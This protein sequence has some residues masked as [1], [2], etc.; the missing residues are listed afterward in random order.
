LNF[1]AALTIG[2]SSEKRTTL[3]DNGLLFSQSS[4]KFMTQKLTF[5][6]YYIECL[7]K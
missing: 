1:Y 4:Y 7:T 6:H 3:G 2:K 5:Y